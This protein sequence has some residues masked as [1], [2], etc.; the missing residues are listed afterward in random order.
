MLQ[1]LLFA[2][3]VG[4]SF[5]ITLL[6]G[7]RLAVDDEQTNAAPGDELLHEVLAH[8]RTEYVDHVDDHE[9]ITAAARGLV[10]DL[11]SHS[12]FLDADQ[13][14]DIRISATGNYSGVGL[15]VTLRGHDVTVITPLADSPAAE[16]GIESGDVIVAIDDHPV[17][18][19]ELYETVRRL[20]G[21]NGT[22]VN[23]SLLTADPAGSRQVM[24][25]RRP[26]SIASVTP[27]LLAPGI[28][29]IRISQ[30]HDQTAIE[31]RSALET[32]RQDNLTPLT[33]LVVDLRDNPGGLLD[34]AI[35]V[36]DLFLDEGLIVTARGRTASARFEQRANHG[37]VAKDAELVVLVNG[38]SASAA[39]ILAAALQDNQRARLLGTSTFGKGLV[40]T[41]V[42][43]S[44]G[45]AIK[46]TTSRYYTPSGQYIDNRGLTPDVVIRQSAADTPDRQLTAAIALLQ[47]PRI[48]L[49]ER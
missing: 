11:D 36:A 3:L 28:G 14:A 17:D 35:D 7:S 6:V 46:L 1:R 8:V 12:Q 9:L 34:A 13:Y 25:V 32:M 44:D 16:A 38:A 29:L 39:E 47:K 10:A 20:R 41:V 27:E 48:I 24:L 22:S 21:D 33:G 43:I 42:P 5:G 19:S 23:L 40:Q 45:Q 18:G 31:V 4:T 15:E 2:L 37:S 49:S 30:F 26:L